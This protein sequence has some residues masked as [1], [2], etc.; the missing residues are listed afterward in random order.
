MIP[1]AF[2]DGHMNVVVENAQGS[3]TS[4]CEPNCF[5]PSTATIPAG[6]TVTFANNDTAAHTSTSGTI[7]GDD[8]GA[9][10]DSSLVMMGSAYTT[11]PLEPG[12][13]PYFCMVH[14]WMTGLVVVEEQSHDDVVME[15]TLTETSSTFANTISVE[16]DSNDYNIE[17]TGNNVI[18]KSATAD[19]EAISIFFETE[20][21]DSNGDI[22]I[23][24]QRDFF[25]A[26]VGVEI[27]DDFWVLADGE[28]INFEETKTDHSRTLSF[29]VSSGT[30]EIE[31]IGTILANYSYLISQENQA[32]ADADAEAKAKADAE[33]KAKAD[34]E[35]KAKADAE[36]KAKADAEAEAN[37]KADAE[38][39][40]LEKLANACGDGTVFENGECVLSPMAKNA[41]DTRT[42]PLIYSIVIGMSIG[43]MIMLI[44]WGI[45]KRS[46]K[47][48][49]DEGS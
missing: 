6:G 21:A 23:N 20:V 45:G 35:A 33:A 34:A 49:S 3:S 31:I 15:Q 42:G 18:L 41:S 24:F 40:R 16:I 14:P 13:Y 29:S 8:A 38:E 26:K 10:W 25:D 36:A 5:I 32:E 1:S 28:E 22:I 46:H 19:L 30:E 17:Y 44:L 43:I 2:A 37:A 7:S 39:Q 11:P 12:E 4:G 9:I 47:V 48:L 27:D